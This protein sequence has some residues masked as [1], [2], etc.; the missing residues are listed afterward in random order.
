ME[1][2]VLA[3]TL[4]CHMNCLHESHCCT[5]GSTS[6]NVS[7]SQKHVTKDASH[8]REEVMRKRG[9]LRRKDE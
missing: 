8:G 9:K 2:K 1:G 4:L 6:G 5:L 3:R 7:S